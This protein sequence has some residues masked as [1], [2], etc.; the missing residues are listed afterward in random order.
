VG[1]SNAIGKHQRHNKTYANKSFV[2]Y[3]LLL[4]L[5]LLVLFVAKPHTTIK[6]Q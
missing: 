6:P 4:V 2:W 5:L 1:S 3:L